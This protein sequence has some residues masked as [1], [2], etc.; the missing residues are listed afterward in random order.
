MAGAALGRL[1]QHRLAGAQLI[2]ALEQNGLRLLGVDGLGAHRFGLGHGSFS[3]LYRPNQP[4]MP[5]RLKLNK[6]R[7]AAPRPVPRRRRSPGTRPA[8]YYAVAG[9]DLREE[10]ERLCR[11]PA[12]GGP[13]GPLVRRPPELA[14][15]RASV[16]PRTRLGFAVPEEHRLSVTAYPG[17]RRGDV[18]ETLLHE[19]VHLAIGSSPGGRRWHGREFTE[20]LR[21]AMREAYGITRRAGEEHLPRD[22]RRGARAEARDGGRAGRARGSSG[23]AGAGGVSGLA[24]VRRGGGGGSGPWPRRGRRPRPSG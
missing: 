17:I 13:E 18:E 15:R 6:P 8:R 16:R 14:V 3:S 20:T 4:G 19:L 7:R 21:R 2:E 9:I 12:L 24:R 11:L 22:V 10:M 23:A 5:I 1:L